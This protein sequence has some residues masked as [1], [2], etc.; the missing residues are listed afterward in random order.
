MTPRRPRIRIRPPAQYCGNLPPVREIH[1]V[2]YRYVVTL[3]CG[4]ELDMDQPES[5][6]RLIPCGQHETHTHATVTAYRPERV[7]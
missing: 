5:I 2:M 1:L 7:K 6:G 4:A 3:D